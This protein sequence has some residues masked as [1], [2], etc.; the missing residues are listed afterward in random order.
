MP[1]KIRVLEDDRSG[2]LIVMKLIGGT[3]WSDGLVV[4]EIADA[5]QLRDDL[6]K[7]LGL[8]PSSAAPAEAPPSVPLSAE[9][10][11]ST[12]RSWRPARQT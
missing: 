9:D 4:V 6:I 2:S 10:Y 1:M 3:P 12:S 8:P 11:L 7:R 5:N